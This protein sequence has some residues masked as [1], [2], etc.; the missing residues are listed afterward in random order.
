MRGEWTAISD[1]LGPEKIILLREP[2]I[3]LE[4]ILVVDNTAAGPAIGGIRMAPDITLNEVA[5]LARAM[6]FKNAAAGLRHGGGKAGIVGDPTML[7]H[8]KERLVRAFGV[9]IRD[10]VDY[11]PGPDMGIDEAC[12]AA[13]YDEIGRV[14]GLPRALGGIPLDTLGAT[15][16]GL[17][18]A[19][20]VADEFG[21]VDLEG[22]RVVIQGFGAVGSHAAR[23][24]VERGAV[25]VAVSDSRGGMAEPGGL[26][27][28]K[29]LLWKSAG[30][31]VSEFAGGTAIAHEALIGYPCDIW[32][33][34]AR[35]DVFTATN[36]ATVTAKLVL[37]GANIPATA[38]AERIFHERDILMIPDFIANAGGVICGAVEYRGGTA[39]HAFATIEE[40]IRENTREVLKRWHR[41][42][43]LP[44]VVAIDMAAE[45]VREAMAYR[46]SF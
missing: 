25:V 46:R 45:R 12:M 13:L 23:F 35:P 44:S 19:A 26:D 9:A 1:D 6:T 43:D 38:D 42:G 22:A 40:R 32:V 29:L 14:V 20:E 8:E 41:S 24:L 11:I 37:P 34:A 36:A 4:G 31:P 2:E 27:I 21:V 17:A 15:A 33:P 18:I 28:E 3:G 5:R 16:F 39:T 7:P 10:I 30:N